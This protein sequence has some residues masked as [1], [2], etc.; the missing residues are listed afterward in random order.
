VALLSLA[1]AA[2]FGWLYFETGLALV[3]EWLTS[4]D[5]SYGAALVAVAV[6]LAWRRR[7]MFVSSLRPRSPAIIGIAVLGFGLMLF[8]VGVIGADVFVTRVSS[9]FVLAGATCF[10][11]GPASTRVMA[12]PLFFL[13]LA[14]PPPTLVV[15]ALTLP[16]QGVA[17][18]IAESTLT[19]AGVSVL[20]DGN[21]LRLPSATLEVAEACSGLRSLI[22]LGALAVLLSWAVDLSWTKRGVMVAAAVPIAVAVNGLRIALTGMACEVWG[23]AAAADPWH[24]IAGW[25][26]FIASVL[27]LL[28]VRYLLG[29]ARPPSG[30]LS[31]AMVGVRVGP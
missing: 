23:R 9:V 5:A 12:V 17:S 6:A 15:T 28:F 10:L 29:T 8:L 26:T 18:R 25:L 14:I 3:R 7:E 1:L 30:E 2:T 27:L 22:S 16:L 19:L 11:A 24:T 31:A 20:R 13:L 21:L 4:A